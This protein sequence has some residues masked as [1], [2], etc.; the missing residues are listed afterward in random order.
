MHHHTEGMTLEEQIGQLLV[1][2]F[3]G[4]T[5]STE[6]INLIQRHH[7]GCIILF[8]RNVKSARQVQEL[9]NSLQQL[10]RAAGQ[11]YPLIINVDQEN[12]MVQRLGNHGT[13]FPGNMALGAIRST[14]ITYEV[15][16]ATGKELSALGINMNLAPVVDVNN[17]PANPVIG[18]RSFGENPQHVSLLA[19]AMIQGYHDAGIITSIKHFPGHGDTSIDSH[20]ALPLIPHDIQR[21]EEIELVPFKS[22]IAA[23]A[24]SVMIAHLYLPKLMQGEMVPSSVSAEIITDLLRVKMGFDGLIITDC[25]EMKAVVD[26]IG[27]EQAAVMAIRAGA[28]LVLISHHYDRQRGASEA[29]KAALLDGTLTPE[30]VR[31]S[32]ERILRLKA[33]MLSWNNLP[34][35]AELATIRNDEHQKLRDH[36]YELSTTVVQDDRHL[37]PI[38]LDHEENLLIIIIHPQMYT[39]VARIEN[40]DDALVDSILQYHQNTTVQIISSQKMR[41]AMKKIRQATAQAALIIVVT[42]NAHGDAYQTELVHNLIATGKPV[43]GIAAYNPY[44][45]LAFPQLATYLTTYEYTPPAL[46]TVACVL[47]GEIPARGHL[48]VSIPLRPTHR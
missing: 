32:A 22:A 14:E 11:R 33:S 43:I 40:A 1:A 31:Q 38:H 42:V 41:L 39:P 13:L 19:D 15:A 34:G 25:L 27:T 16:R 7:V 35:D 37:L 46:Q 36:A 29:I 18:V 2:G 30:R 24:D 5:P 3:S 45:L 10:A 48:P 8:A 47:F 6:I 26:T 9:T 17:N 20:F 12:G 44:D 23:G 21:L 4:T 28:D